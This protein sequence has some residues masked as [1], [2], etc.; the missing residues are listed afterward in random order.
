MMA[1]RLLKGL[2]LS[3]M[4]T[5]LMPVLIAEVKAAVDVYE[6]ETAEQEQRFRTLSNEFRCPMCQNANLSSSPGGVAADLRREIYRMIMEG[7][8]D[9]QIEA[10]MLA[11]Y[12][13]FILYRPRLT[14]Q[15]VLLWFGPLL[16]LVIG[17]WAAFS[18]MRRSGRQSPAST[19]SLSSDEEARLKELLAQKK[20]DASDKA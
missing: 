3:L 10:F 18:I 19:Q 14:L 11:R 17:I 6:F 8:T 13:D 15:T 16:F 12:G 20:D 7:Q 4:L 5:L 9:Q 2:A 1:A